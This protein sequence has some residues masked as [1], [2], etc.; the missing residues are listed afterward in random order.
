MSPISLLDQCA[1]AIQDVAHQPKCNSVV[2]GAGFPCGCYLQREA[3]IASGL[4]DAIRKALN[5]RHR[6][7]PDRELAVKILDAFRRGAGKEV[8]REA[9]DG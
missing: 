5:E 9:T 4:H 2:L 8:V 7:M 6:M 3:Q 1:K